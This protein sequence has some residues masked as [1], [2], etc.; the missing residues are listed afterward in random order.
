MREK[1]FI[2]VKDI[3]VIGESCL[4]RFL[5]CDAD[6]LCP[7]I[8]VP[9]LT[10]KRES[11]NEGMA[12]NVYRNIKILINN[13][14]IRTNFNW[15]EIKKTR[16]IDEKSNHMFIRVDDDHSAIPTLDVDSLDLNDYKLIAISDYNKGYL[17][18]EAISFICNNHDN[19]FLDSKKKIG[20]WAN[21]AKY[22][23]INNYEL[24]RSSDTITDIALS[25]TICTKGS[26][27]CDFNGK[28]YPV[29]KVDVKDPCGAGD[30][31]FAALV[32]HFLKSEDIIKSINYAN[33]AASKVVSQRGVTTL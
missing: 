5:Y 23:K 12:Q 31:F 25:K 4:D 10:V 28:N 6:R 21:E 22:I 15:K 1:A 2:K 30:T 16:Y 7:D 29:K 11:T 32:C 3:L 20:E 27:G 9:A 26:D 13:C 17:T 24:D 19:V 18:K 8:P 33:N 14:D